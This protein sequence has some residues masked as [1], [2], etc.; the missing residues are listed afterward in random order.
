MAGFN[1]HFAFGDGHF[2]GSFAER[3]FQAI[4]DKIRTMPVN[5]A[6]CGVQTSFQIKF[7]SG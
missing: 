1:L 3:I 4:S 5:M 2:P 6:D 7:P